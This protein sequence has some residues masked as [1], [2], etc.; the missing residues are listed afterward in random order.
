MTKIKDATFRKTAIAF[1]VAGSVAVTGA[2]GASSNND[3]PEPTQSSPTAEEV[4]AREPFQGEIDFALPPGFSEG[5]KVSDSNG[6]YASLVLDEDSELMVFDKD[7]IIDDSVYDHYSEEELADGQR[8]SSTFVVEEVIDS[9]LMYDYSEENAKEWGDRNILTFRSSIHDEVRDDLMNSEKRTAI[10]E[11]NSGWDRGAPVYDGGVRHGDLDVSLVSISS[12][13]GRESAIEFEYSISYNNP[14]FDEDDPDN[15][16]VET[17]D[18]SYKTRVEKDDSNGN[19]WVMA[20]IASK[21]TNEVRQL[22]E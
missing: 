17:S 10:T 15:L 1:M 13:E 21:F 18:H 8:F 16:Y 12:T 5:E 19:N 22:E 7:K 6:E 9:S 14:V 20:S 2:C 3:T 4:D 11:S